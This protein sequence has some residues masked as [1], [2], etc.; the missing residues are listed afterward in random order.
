MVPSVRRGLFCWIS[1]LI[2]CSNGPTDV[3]DTGGHTVDI[4]TGINDTIEQ[5]CAATG[6]KPVFQVESTV[7]GRVDV[8]HT[9][10]ELPNCGVYHVFM[11]FKEIDWVILE[12]GR[13][14]DYNEVCTDTCIWTFTYE[15]AME[16]GDW[17]FELRPSGETRT[18]TVR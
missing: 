3:F 12:Y 4:D 7:P 8:R 13:V 10:Y 11:E 9:G 18:V 14:E 15:I 2:G 5:H 1:L 17:T 16:E 6:E